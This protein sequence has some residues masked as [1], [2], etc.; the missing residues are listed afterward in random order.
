MK[1]YEEL[2]D[3]WRYLIFYTNVSLSIFVFAVEV[4]MYLVLARGNL[5]LRPLPEYFLKFLILP[6]IINCAVICLGYI[7]LKIS[8]PK[9]IFI[10]YIPIIQM[11]VICLVIACTHN[12]F[13]VT[14]CI[15]S[16]PIFTT[17]IFNDK[18]MTRRIA[19][20]N[21]LF[22][23]FAFICRK[24]SVSNDYLIPEALVAFSFT[25]SVY[26]VCNILINYQEE[27]DML[28]VK[29]YVHEIRMQQMLNKDQKTGLYGHTA[30]LNTLKRKTS[31][32]DGFT[33]KFS[34]AIID[35]DDFKKVND[36]YGHAV[37]DEI[38]IALAEL[39]KKYCSDNHLPA[40]F[41]G[42]E[43]AIILNEQEKDLCYDFI[44]KL[45][46]DFE[47]KTSEIINRAVT[48]SCGIAT[49]TPSLTAEELFNKADSAMYQ[50]KATGK[51]RTTILN[52]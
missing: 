46:K 30:L 19:L 47:L 25:I 33:E 4:L 26:I 23:I 36:T 22:L 20:L 10:N 49:W 11:S 43:F 3:K 5:I 40:R 37:G 27:K 42:E 31:V 9:K 1:D 13:S 41:G 32:E 29:G 15:F 45:R 44:E 28:V 12:F 8:S 52:K 50:S 38:I 34:L 7:F 14:Q 24:Y 17:L 2:Y 16:I 39:M 21:C 48:I 18:T 51:N 6:T 35:V